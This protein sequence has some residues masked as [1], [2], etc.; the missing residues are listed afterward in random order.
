MQNNQVHQRQPVDG[1]YHPDHSGRYSWAYYWARQL[2][3]KAEADQFS[4]IGPHLDAHNQMAYLM[5][6]IGEYKADGAGSLTV[7]VRDRW[8]L[9]AL[10]SGKGRMNLDTARPAWESQRTAQ[11]PKPARPSLQPPPISQ[12]FH[13]AMSPLV[14]HT[15]P[16]AIA[17]G[18]DK[19]CAH[20]DVGCLAGQCNH[21]CCWGYISDA[22][23]THIHGP[24]VT[25]EDYFSDAGNFV[26]PPFCYTSGGMTKKTLLEMTTNLGIQ[27]QHSRTK[28]AKL[29]ELIRGK[30]AS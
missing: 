6:R 4:A 8:P 22:H 10:M 11:E 24:G 23:F 20:S 9:E 29:V 7:A 5:K 17:W 16:E 28:N 1:A 18:L 14:G 2:A 15:E 13:K 26:L 27:S 12:L 30:L 25:Q 21:K 19:L 3:V